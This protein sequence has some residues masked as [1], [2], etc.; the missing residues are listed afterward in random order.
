MAAAAHPSALCGSVDAA[1][2]TSAA[3]APPSPPSPPR[4][5]A[6]NNA[7]LMRCCHCEAAAAAVDNS[8]RHGFAAT[9]DATAANDQRTSGM[10]RSPAIQHEFLLHTVATVKLRTLA[11][12]AGPAG[13][14]AVRVRATTPGDR[15]KTT[16]LADFGRR[17]AADGA[18]GEADGRSA[19]AVGG[20]SMIRYGLLMLIPLS[21]VAAVLFC[22]CN[23]SG[24]R[25]NRTEL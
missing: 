11:L 10:S 21:A 8:L 15:P 24:G 9:P 23:S 6:N 25:D 4:I 16:V 13:T 18:D 22:K 1:T 17:T 3:A 5:V 19:S 14:M 2:A 12:A 20:R 7:H